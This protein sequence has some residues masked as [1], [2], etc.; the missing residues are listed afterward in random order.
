LV[1]GRILAHLKSNIQA[2]N[3]QMGSEDIEEIEKAYEFDSGFPNNWLNPSGKVPHG[4]EDI[5]LLKDLGYF[6][7][8]QRPKAIQA[9]QGELNGY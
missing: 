2:L 7:Y 9:H 8:V 5:R 3:V 1:G 6:D 4:P